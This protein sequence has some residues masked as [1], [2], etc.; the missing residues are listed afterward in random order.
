[1]VIRIALFLLL[2]V[3]LIT[4]SVFGLSILNLTHAVI[5]V[6]GLAGVAG[7]ALGFAFRDIAENLYFTRK[8]RVAALL[9]IA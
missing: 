4:V 9:N 5:S 6:L 1:M 3:A 2:V 8:P 7:L